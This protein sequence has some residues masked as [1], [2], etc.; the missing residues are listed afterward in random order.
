LSETDRAL[1]KLTESQSKKNGG[2]GF[3]ESP[4]TY[5]IYDPG[6]RQKAGRKDSPE[7]RKTAGEPRT[8]S[9]EDVT[10][11]TSKGQKRLGEQYPMQFQRGDGRYHQLRRPKEKEQKG[12]NI[13]RKKKSITRRSMVCTKNVVP[14][15]KLYSC[16]ASGRRRK[17][18]KA[19]Y[20]YKKER[21]KEKRQ[22][23]TV[24]TNR[25]RG[26]KKSTR[27]QRR[28]GWKREGGVKDRDQQKHEKG[29]NGRVKTIRKRRR[30]KFFNT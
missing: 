26:T 19:I 28:G 22:T 11:F 24:S 20:G 21:K 8:Q 6:G 1:K 12:I 17:A 29:G 7:K 9:E 23:L 4:T 2:G 14:G 18:R 30:M 16:G 3:V 15:G 5:Y 27:A 10:G 25:Q 13:I